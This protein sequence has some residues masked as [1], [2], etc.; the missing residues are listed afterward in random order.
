MIYEPGFNLFLESVKRL[1]SQ[2]YSIKNPDL[3][4]YNLH[5]SFFA[6]MKKEKDVLRVPQLR[7]MMLARLFLKTESNSYIC[8]T[9][10][11]RLTMR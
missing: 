6:E 1:T 9:K 8:L 10:M 7:F 11:K 3:F 2:G 5:T 4:V